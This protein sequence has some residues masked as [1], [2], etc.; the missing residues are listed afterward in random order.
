[1][2]TGAATRFLALRVEPLQ[3]TFVRYIRNKHR[4]PR[5]RKERALKF[6]KVNLPDYEQMR[7]QARG[8]LTPEEIRSIMKKEGVAPTRPYQEKP[9][10]ITTTDTIMEPFI[11]PEGDGRASTLSKEGMKE[12]YNVLQKKGR[13][14]LGL[15]KIRRFEEEFDAG[16]FALVAQDIYIDAHNLLVKNDLEKLHDVVTEHAYP[17]MIDGIDTKTI[18]WK[19]HESIE[20][21]RLVHARVSPLLTKHNLYGQVTVRIHSRQSLAVYD[22]FGRIMYGSENLVKNVLEY[23]VF[24]KHLTNPY[25][26]W[27]LHAKIVP[28]WAPPVDPV[29]RTFRK[30]TL[31]APSEEYLAKLREKQ[32][33]ED[34]ED[35]AESTSTNAKPTV[36]T[37]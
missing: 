15:R 4:D 29:I 30:P 25:G 18:K 14:M 37:A 32:K 33:V 27:R 13:T 28:A 21:P 3:L 22:R 23:V 5:F 36:A 35:E 8:Q 9:L 31:E 24:E 6:I 11:P 7:R 26:V 17:D 2:L 1:M 20:L 19:W 12:R 34:L 16:D 10:L